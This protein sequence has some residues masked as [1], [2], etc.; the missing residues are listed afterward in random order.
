MKEMLRSKTPGS[1][2]GGQEYPFETR[3]RQG[4]E[5]DWRECLWDARSQPATHWEGPGDPRLALPLLYSPQ[6]GVPGEV[7]SVNVQMNQRPTGQDVPA[8]VTGKGVRGECEAVEV[9][10][11]GTEMENRQVWPRWGTH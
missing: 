1:C 9:R 6:G 5:T 11:G 10:D 3:D 8:H 7:Y 4:W 2:S